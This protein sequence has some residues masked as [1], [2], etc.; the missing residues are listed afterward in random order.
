VAGA[1]FPETLEW[2]ANVA[3]LPHVPP[4][5]HPAFYAAQLFTL[6]ITRADMTSVGY[7]PSVRLFEA[8]ACGVPIVSDAWPGLETIFRPDEEIIIVE[9]TDEVMRLLSFFPEEQRQALGVAARRRVLA[10]HSGSVRAR[11]LERHL[12]GASQAK[13]A[14]AARRPMEEISQ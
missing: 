6:N 11:Q 1:Q 7:S 13:R 3:R 8:A 5:E 9:T 14:S 10:E 2:P 12:L 4:A